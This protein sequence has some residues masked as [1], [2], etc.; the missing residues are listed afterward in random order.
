MKQESELQTIYDW[1]RAKFNGFGIYKLPIEERVN[2]L[3]ELTKKEYPNMDNYLI[4]YAL[5]IKY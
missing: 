2:E 1:T 4:G 3:I 5:L